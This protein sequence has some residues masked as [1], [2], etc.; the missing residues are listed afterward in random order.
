MEFAVSDNPNSPFNVVAPNTPL[1]MWLTFDPVANLC[2][3]L[4]R[5]MF[6]PSGYATFQG[7][8]YDVSGGIEVHNGFGNEC[9]IPDPTFAPGDMTDYVFRIFWQPTLL[10]PDYYSPEFFAPLIYSY[11][12]FFA[13][14][15]GQTLDPE[16]LRLALLQMNHSSSGLWFEA[17]SYPSAVA[18]GELQSIE[19][20][21]EPTTLLLFGS[22]F[23]GLVLR[24]RSAGHG[25]N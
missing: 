12:F 7:K 23:L 20:V 14:F 22:G 2:T 11:M 18:F 25:K 17:E 13:P 3:E 4:G 5:G 10:F 16:E 21:P 1:R 24:R 9:T 19:V 6:T 8:T 15:N